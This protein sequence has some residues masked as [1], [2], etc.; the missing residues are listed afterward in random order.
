MMCRMVARE[1][2]DEFW[3]MDEEVKL[4][5]LLGNEVEGI[6]N[7]VMEDVGECV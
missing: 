7:S 3:R 4:S 2:L 5:L 1:W 6:C